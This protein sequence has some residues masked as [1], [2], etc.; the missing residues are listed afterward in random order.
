MDKWING[1]HKSTYVQSWRGPSGLLLWT[2][3]TGDGTDKDSANEKFY[4]TPLLIGC[5]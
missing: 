5:I 1:I 2:L 4:R 3:L